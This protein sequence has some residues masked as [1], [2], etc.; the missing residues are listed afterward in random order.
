M[1]QSNKKIKKCRF[2]PNFTGMNLC[3][4]LIPFLFLLSFPVIA[5]AQEEMDNLDDTE[6][7]GLQ[8]VKGFHFGFNLGAY[9]PNKYPA[10]LYDGYGFDINGNKNTFINSLMYRKIVVESG[11]QNGNGD[12]IAE[13]LG[14][15]AGQWHF[16]ESNMPVDLEY[17]TGFLLGIH[18]NYGFSK[19]ESFIFNFN[20][21]KLTITGNFTIETVPP[22][23]S[24]QLYETIHNFPLRGKE[25][26][27]FI[28]LG[29]SRIFGNN[30]VINPVVEGGFSVNYAGMTKYF[31]QINDLTLDLTTFNNVYGYTDYKPEE[32]TGWGFGVFAGLGTYIRVS[33]KYTAQVLYSPSYDKINIGLEPKAQLQ[34]AFSIRIYYL[35]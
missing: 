31:I 29:Y 25:D 13:Q 17:K 22:I 33:K 35:L 28:Q 23:G 8:S 1:S 9:F 3:K 18:A 21:T 7:T 5:K 34:N 20:Y 30:K 11:G 32:Y 24:N 26:R 10:G 27:T 4:N 14:V 12:L 19:R 2:C 6:I 15:Q 16:F